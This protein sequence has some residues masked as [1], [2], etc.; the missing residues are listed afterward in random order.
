DIPGQV[1]SARAAGAADTR[2]RRR[3]SGESGGGVP[4]G[5]IWA[6]EIVA[7]SPI[8]LLLG[9]SDRAHSSTARWARASEFPI[10]HT[11]RRPADAASRHL[12]AGTC[13]DHPLLT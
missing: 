6:A 10:K 3:R 7:G 1:A 13:P 5:V 2:G 11:L 9:R 12:T 4:C 8:Q